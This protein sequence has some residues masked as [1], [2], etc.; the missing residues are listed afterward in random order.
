MLEPILLVFFDPRG[1]EAYLRFFEFPFL[2]RFVD[3]SYVTLPDC[4]IESIYSIITWR[5]PGGREWVEP[6]VGGSLFVRFLGM[7]PLCKW[8]R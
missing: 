1:Y 6:E 4:S 5:T 8:P 2:L 7:M 3:R